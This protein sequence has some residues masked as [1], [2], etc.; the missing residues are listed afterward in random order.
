MFVDHFFHLSVILST[1]CIYYYPTVYLSFP[2]DFIYHSVNIF[3]YLF[4]YTLTCVFVCRYFFLFTLKPKSRQQHQW[5][6]SQPW[7]WW[8][9]TGRQTGEWLANLLDTFCLNWSV[10]CWHTN[11]H[12]KTDD[13]LNFI[14]CFYLILECRPEQVMAMYLEFESWPCPFKA[15]HMFM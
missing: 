12:F 5:K 3:I 11:N 15:G 4:L 6:L 13:K 8:R 1:V 2:Q 10:R 14:R 9:N 7:Q